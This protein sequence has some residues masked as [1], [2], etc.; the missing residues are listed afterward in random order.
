MDSGQLNLVYSVGQVLEQ[1]KK[2]SCN[3]CT[4]YEFPL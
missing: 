4:N 1:C 2:V 3:L